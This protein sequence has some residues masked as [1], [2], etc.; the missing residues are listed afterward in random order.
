MVQMALLEEEHP[1]LLGSLADAM[2]AD[3][4]AEQ[5]EKQVQALKQKVQ[6]ILNEHIRAGI[7]SEGPFKIV[8]DVS[9]RRL[10]NIERLKSLF[11]SVFQTVAHQKY[12][13]S[14]TD[15]EKILS[16]QDLEAV[17]TVQE[18]KKTRLDWDYRGRV[19]T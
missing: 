19:E 15:V 12:T 13:A 6:G 14:V 3:C 11:P 8:E 7:L 10:V 5:L 9:T 17:I 16:G 2:D 1:F 18:T 4:E